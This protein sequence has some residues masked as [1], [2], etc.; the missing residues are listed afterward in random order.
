MKNLFFLSKFIKS[1]HTFVPI[2]RIGIRITADFGDNIIHN[3]I[4]FISLNIFTQELFKAKTHFHGV[5]FFKKAVIVSSSVTKPPAVTGSA[6]TGHYGKV[7]ALR[8][9]SI[10]AVFRLKNAERALRKVVKAFYFHRFHYTLAEAFRDADRFAAFQSVSDYP[11]GW[12]LRLGADIDKQSFTAFIQPGI[13]YTVFYLP[14]GSAD[15]FPAQGGNPAFNFISNV[16]FIHTHTFNNRRKF[17]RVSS[18][19]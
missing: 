8:A 6:Y 10:F 11:Y 18:G 12:R 4:M 14:A 17:R 16:R 7:D 5:I 13:Y 19:V 2:K 15:I 3:N 1:V 9:E